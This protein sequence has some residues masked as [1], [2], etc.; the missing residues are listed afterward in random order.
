ML[1]SFRED[2]PILCPVPTDTWRVQPMP[3]S[4]LLMK[5]ATPCTHVH[6]TLEA[7]KQWRDHQSLMSPGQHIVYAY[8]LR[9]R[10]QNLIESH[11][12]I[13]LSST[14]SIHTW[15]LTI[16]KGLQ[17]ANKQSIT[18][19]SPHYN[20]IIPHVHVSP[21][22]IAMYTCT[23][24]FRVCINHIQHARMHAH[25]KFTNINTYIY[26]YTCIYIHTHVH[27]CTWTHKLL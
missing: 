14:A 12:P 23:G 17:Y 24:T 10:G 25:T 11:K 13:L 19:K 8:T 18:Q 3:A 2:C 16:H 22:F 27:I 9:V 15:L 6:F 21:C 1:Q 7:P 4:H 26:K 20:K 5:K